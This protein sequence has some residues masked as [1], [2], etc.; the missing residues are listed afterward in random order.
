MRPMPRSRLRSSLSII[1]DEPGEV[2]ADRAYDALVAPMMAVEKAIQVKGGLSKLM[3]KG[4]RWLPAKALEAD[5]RP[6]SSAAAD[7]CPDRENLWGLEA[8]LSFSL[9]AM[10]GLGA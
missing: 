8:P 3:R 10:D 4:H 9:H 2:Y 7:P 1:P 6:L 5:H